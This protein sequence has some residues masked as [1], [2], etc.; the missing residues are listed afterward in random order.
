MS[1]DAKD[2]IESVQTL[3]EPHELDPG[4][5]YA[6]PL[7]GEGQVAFVHPEEKYALAPRRPRGVSTVIDVDSFAVLWA[8]HSDSYSEVFA[9]QLRDEIV[10]VLNADVGAGEDAGFRDHRIQLALRSTVAWRVWLDFAGKWHNQ[11]EFAEFIEDRLGDITNPSGAD[12]MELATSLEATSSGSFK[13]AVSLSS[14][15][16]TLQFEETVQA[17]AGQ[18]GQLEIPKE[19]EI[20]ISPYEGVDPYRV[21]C[22]FRYRIRNGTLSL[23]LW[24]DRPEDVVKAAFD[25]IVDELAQA[26]GTTVLRGTPPPETL[27]VR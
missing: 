16:R 20:A 19:I 24:I 5:H 2:I 12:V 23:G 10:G 6:I 14:G 8:K 3:S 17:K 26:T 27:T 11:I 18:T 7:A 4:K 1:S 15:S 21:T 25:G 9:D 22:R 13:S